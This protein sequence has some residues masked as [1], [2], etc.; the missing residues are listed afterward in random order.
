MFIER[1]GERSFAPPYQA[2]NVRLNGYVLRGNI[3]EMQ[4]L[5]DLNLN[6]VGGGRSPIFS[7]LSANV[8]LTIESMDV[9]LPKG[10]AGILPVREIAVWIPVQHPGGVGFFVSHM[11]IDTDF[12]M[13]T[14]RDVLGFPKS[15]V[16]FEAFPGDY[17]RPNAFAANVFAL[18][19]FAAEERLSMRRLMDV[20]L[21]RSHDISPPPESE[22]PEEFAQE[23]AK[24][25]L[26]QQG[27]GEPAEAMD[28]STLNPARTTRG[29]IAGR[30]FGWLARPIPVILLKEHR[31]AED[32][33]KA[34]FRRLVS[35]SANL[36]QVRRLGW[37]PGEY[38]IRFAE[39]DSEPLH[40]LIP[41]QSVEWP[42]AF[43]MDFD[44]SIGA[45]AY[46]Y[47]E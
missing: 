2:S 41:P 32:P 33:G 37:L 9:R 35:V 3:E 16:N 44:F 17:R 21:S 45:G 18:R 14:G 11:Y 34:C 27:D 8:L 47:G 31:D 15:Y 46:L 42:R 10:M 39:L 29:V 23:I 26:G 12:G 40:R 38:R 4:R 25:L 19:R 20:D 13:F 28:T 5:C 43:Y 22:D 1:S 24:L 30:V 36:D 7:P 6:W